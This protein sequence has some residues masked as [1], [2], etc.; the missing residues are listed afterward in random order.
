MKKILSYGGGV[1]TR[2][3]GRL[4]LDGRVER[5]DLVAFADT[6]NEPLRIMQ[7]ID[8][9][10]ALLE[11]A[12]VECV[13]V[14][15]GDLADWRGNGSIHVPLY[16]VSTEGRWVEPGDD[17]DEGVQFYGLPQDR[18]ERVWAPAGS[19]GLLRRTCTTRFKTECVESEARF[20]GWDRDGY[21]L[22]IGFTTDEIR[23]VKPS[24]RNYITSRWP[25][26]ELDWR[27]SNCE[28]LLIEHNQPITKSSCV[29]CPYKS[30]QKWELLRGPD[31]ERAIAYDESIRDARLGFKSYVHRWFR[32]LREIMAEP[33]EPILLPGLSLE[34]ECD[35]GGCWT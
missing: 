12:G 7:L 13:I 33:G 14:N 19:R 9:E 17:E 4:V 6:K 28:A 1:Q 34:D 5:P 27:R 35:E 29:F 22:W 2:A 23:R 21:E 8:Q 3:L 26:I 11:S 16:I 30:A 20:R 10:F 25:L 24:K 31:L 18:A 32:P 15:R